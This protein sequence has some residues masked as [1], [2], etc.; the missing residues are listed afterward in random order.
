MSERFEA[1]TAYPTGS[2]TIAR[3]AQRGTRL[4]YDGIVVRNGE[5]ALRSA[6]VDQIREAYGIDVITAVELA[7]AVPDDVSG[8]LP[9][10]GREQRL[11][12]VQGGTR[13]INR[14]VANQRDVDVLT[15]PITHEGPSVGVAVAKA[16]IE[17]DVHVEIDLSP[18]REAGGRRVRYIDRL[19]RLWRLIDHYDVPYVV[20]IRPQSHLEL[21]S[22]H[23][24]AALG[25]AVGLDKSAVRTGLENMADLAR[26]VS[27]P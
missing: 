25:T 23:D 21:V 26:T 4:G 5:T 1:V 16:A 20:S 9:Q 19:T 24:L 12:F 7:P 13:R 11:V 2:S 14:F 22:V 6:A 3:F 27:E 18:L 15:R 8:R 17:H 10:L